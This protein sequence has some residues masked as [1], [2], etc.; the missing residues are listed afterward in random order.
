MD[1]YTANDI[2]ADGARIAARLVA[3]SVASGEIVNVSVSDCDAADA[4]LACIED[5]NAYVDATW[6]DICGAP[7]RDVTGESDA[8]DFRIMI[9][10][11]NAKS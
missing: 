10:I 11:T 1:T 5:D 6:L 4:L 7:V 3:E 8:G 2:E 9:H